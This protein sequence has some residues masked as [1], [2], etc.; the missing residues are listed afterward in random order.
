[1]YQQPAPTYDPAAFQ[2]PNAALP[3]PPANLSHPTFPQQPQQPPQMAAYSNGAYGALQPNGMM[4]PYG[5]QAAGQQQQQQQWPGAAQGGNPA[6]PPPPASFQAGAAASAYGAMPSSG[7]LLQ[8]QLAAQA[9]QIAAQ[10]SPAPSAQHASPYQNQ[11]QAHQQLYQSRQQ[12]QPPNPQLPIPPAQ[13]AYPSQPAPPPP[14]QTSAAAAPAGAVRMTTEQMTHALRGVQFQGMSPEKFAQLTP[15]QQAGLREYMARSRAAQQAQLGL[16][17]P[18]SPAT[19]ASTPS[20]PPAA[21][22]LGG[23]AGV[24]GTASPAPVNSALRQVQQQQSQPNSTMSPQQQTFHR[25]LAEFYAKKGQQFAG[26]PVV[27]GQQLDLAKL[28]TMVTKMGGFEAV[29]NNRYWGHVAQTLGFIAPSPD[30]QPESR[31]QALAQAYQQILLPFQ[32]GWA[33]VQQQRLRA[34][35]AAAAASGR[36]GSAQALPNGASPSLTSAFPPQ[37]P[38]APTPSALNISTPAAAASPFTAPLPIPPPAQ[39]ASNTIDLTAGVSSPFATSAPGSRPLTGTS[40]GQREGT[41][42]LLDLKGKGKA[43]E[44]SLLGIKAEP[45]TIDLTG[46][47]K[48]TSSLLPSTDTA[49]TS[50]SPVTAARPSTSSGAATSADVKP[51]A[52]AEPAEPPRR[53]RRKIEYAPMVRPVETYGGLDLG[54]MEQTA[55]KVEKTRRKRNLHDLGTVDIHSLTMQLRSRLPSEVAYALNALTLVVQQMSLDRGDGGLEFPLS[56]CPDLAEELFDLLEETAFGFGDEDEGY[57]DEEDE[58]APAPAEVTDKAPFVPP[59]SYRELFRLVADEASALLPPPPRSERLNPQR[60][61]ETIL[62]VLNLVRNLSQNGDNATFLGTDR[63]ILDILARVSALPLEQERRT[64]AP[65]PV[66]VSP[67]D[68]LAIKKDVLETINTFGLDVRLAELETETAQKVVDL[69]VFFLRDAHHRD[70]LYVDLSAPPSSSASR[71]PQAAQLLIPPYLEMGLSTF[72]R[73]ALLD[74]NRSTIAR[75]LPPETVYALFESLV[76]L[77]PVHEA[78]FQLC[79]FEPG[80]V[81]VYHV[82]LGLYNLAFVAPPSIKLRLRAEPRFVRSLVRIVRRLAGTTMAAKDGD[83]FIGLAQ[84]CIGVLQLL[85]NLGGVAAVSSSSTSTATA[86]SEASDVPWWGLSMSG[87]DDDEDDPSSS[88]SVGGADG[89]P[90]GRSRSTL[91]ARAPAPPSS[92]AASALLASLG[93]PVLTGDVRSLWELVQQG[94]MALVV[95]QLM[96]LADGTTGGRR[97]RK[98]EKVKGKEKGKEGEGEKQREGAEASG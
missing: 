78:D 70:Q 64:T 94:S 38:S 57:F 49:A 66:H 42:P 85:N 34:A 77:L 62:A 74:A 93:P 7:A 4:N 65:F 5:A 33:E 41:A 51:V 53:K 48:P 10:G 18:G 29:N 36:P 72:A 91:L 75:L 50:A 97:R 13:P 89:L 83:L 8:Q 1:M 21:A 68:S 27:E 71:L 73:V 20:K 82:A 14:S 43:V 80:L 60:S 92:S 6:F 58:P 59:T 17:L 9:A 79:T 12:S 44:D 67:A 87:G 76:Y 56:R 52:P 86:T 88:S 28:F 37:T 35:Q 47:P 11:Q 16:G 81:H 30:Q 19:A 90:S 23:P 63:R 61:A 15:L 40:A 84:R 32:Q 45:G 96:E 55:A 69:V 54:L 98:E 95:A 2:Q 24:G 3:V 25:A 39:P 46:T 26:A 22:G 31:L